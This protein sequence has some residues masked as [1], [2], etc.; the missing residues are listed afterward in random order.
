MLHQITWHQYLTAILLLAI[1]YYAVII[2]RFYQSE[3]QRL[4]NKLQGSANSSQLPGA[5]QYEPEENEL[6]QK[7]RQPGFFESYHQQP[8]PITGYDHLSGELK[9]CIA[10]AAD[11][12]FAPAILIPQL[13][14]TLQIPCEG[15]ASTDRDAI[16]ELIVNECERTGTALLTEDEVD[17][18]WSS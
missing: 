11:K 4:I 16:N 14:K 8:E 5:L 13:K 18:W 6:A 9:A 1:I 12:P 17:Q 10:R 7:T 3:I 15:I 2:F